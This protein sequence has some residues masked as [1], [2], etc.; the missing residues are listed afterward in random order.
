VLGDVWIER[1]M[2][3]DEEGKYRYLLDE[4]LGAKEGMPGEPVA[5]G[6]G[7][8]LGELYAVWEVRGGIKPNSAWWAIASFQYWKDHSAVGRQGN[9]PVC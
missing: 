1:R 8:V 9:R 3:R 4:A 7:D 6:P 5:R 2:Y